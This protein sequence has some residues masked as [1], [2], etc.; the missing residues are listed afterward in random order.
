MEPGCSAIV[1][2][3]NPE[4]QSDFSHLLCYGRYY[5]LADTGKPF[6]TLLQSCQ[7]RQNSH[8]LSITHNSTALLTGEEEAQRVPISEVMNIT[9]LP[10]KEDHLLSPGVLVFHPHFLFTWTFLLQLL[11][12]LY[13]YLRV[14]RS[15]W[16]TNHNFQFRRAT[17]LTSHLFCRGSHLHSTNYF[18]YS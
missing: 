6:P 12:E 18:T 13:L 7:H 3:G 5:Q 14:L 15:S 10:A 16:K 1:M 11:L 9:I 8:E 4:L 2:G 17:Y